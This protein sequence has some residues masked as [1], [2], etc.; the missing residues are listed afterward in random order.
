M[1]IHYEYLPYTKEDQLSQTRQK[2]RRGVKGKFSTKIITKILERDNGRCVRC[3]TYQNLE[4]VP[5]HIIFRSQGGTGTVDNGVT[6]CRTCH[7]WAH[8]CREGREWFEHYR[9]ERLLNH[10]R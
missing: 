6:V 4:S 9:E 10:D 5:H 7:D 3:G 1:S 8:S 2:K